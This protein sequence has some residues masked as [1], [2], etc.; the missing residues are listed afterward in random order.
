M[1]NDDVMNNQIQQPASNESFKKSNSES[2]NEDEMVNNKDDSNNH[3][4]S[5]GNHLNGSDNNKTHSGTADENLIDFESSVTPG[6]NRT[7]HH[8]HCH[9][10][11]MIKSLI[12]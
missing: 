12:G 3:I 9:H 10:H 7:C 6:Q 2:M 1:G 5:N 4:M 11:Q 8:R